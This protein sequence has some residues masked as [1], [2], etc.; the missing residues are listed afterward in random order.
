MHIS[1]SKLQDQFPISNVNQLLYLRILL[2]CYLTSNFLLNSPVFLTTLIDII[3]FLCYWLIIY[4][5]ITFKGCPII[6]L[7]KNNKQILNENIHHSISNKKCKV[8]NITHVK[9]ISNLLIFKSK[10]IQPKT[11][12]KFV[13]LM[14]CDEDYIT[15]ID[16]SKHIK[17]NVNNT[18]GKFPEHFFIN[19]IGK[20]PFLLN[21]SHMNCFK[22]DDSVFFLTYG[23]IKL[24]DLKT[25]WL[26]G[27]IIM[28][29]LR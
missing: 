19:A 29:F 23:V 8:K 20:I 6:S 5:Q 14:T 15:L 13:D 16:K 3:K 2:S 4:R 10:I 24:F 21:S 28:C 26:N 25:Q 11:N 9:S 22:H 18:F 27:R 17:P 12:D 7:S 1:P